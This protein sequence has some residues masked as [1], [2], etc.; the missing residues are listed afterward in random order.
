MLSRGGSAE[1]Y[2]FDNRDPQIE[3]PEAGDHPAHGSVH[4]K[5]GQARIVIEKLIIRPQRRVPG[6]HKHDDA[7]INADDDIEVQ[8]DAPKPEGN[9]RGPLRSGLPILHGRTPWRP[10][11]K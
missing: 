1:M 6:D 10:G 5:R 2:G 8:L 3:K 7:D 9:S 11:R 4:E